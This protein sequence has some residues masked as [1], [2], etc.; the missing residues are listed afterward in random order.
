LLFGASEQASQVL[1]SQPL[2]LEALWVA[3]TDV[4]HDVQVEVGV[5]LSLVELGDLD[6]QLFSARDR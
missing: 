1:A 3:L 2:E 6:E 5:A 4:F